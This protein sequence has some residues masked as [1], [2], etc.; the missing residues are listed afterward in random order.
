MY[1]ITQR[2]RS[3]YIHAAIIIMLA[4]LLS[5]CIGGASPG[6]KF[7]ILNPVD[8]QPLQGAEADVTHV[9]VTAVRLP[10]YLERPQIVT[11]TDDNRI[12]LSE[13]NQWGGNLR[14]NMTRTLSINLSRLLNTSNITVIPYRGIAK[15]D[16]RIEIDVLKFEK[17]HDQKVRLSA[18]WRITSGTAEEIIATRI[19]ELESAAVD[20]TAN[21]ESTVKA[22][23]ELYG[24]LSEIIAKTILE[25]EATT[26]K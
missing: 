21:Y 23:T 16:Y 5:G 11:R 20:G 1:Y 22:M 26:A 18:H 4:T 13:Y 24:K 10:Q 6:I 25:A 15:P 3:Y 14:K 9:E 12:D 7:Y 17:D 19:S 8:G 2:K